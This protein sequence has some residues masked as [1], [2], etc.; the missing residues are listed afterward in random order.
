M[1]FGFSHTEARTRF[2]SMCAQPSLAEALGFNVLWGHEHH[3]G[4]S[5]YPSPLMTLATP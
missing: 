1:R 4:G 5:M 3:S 2:D